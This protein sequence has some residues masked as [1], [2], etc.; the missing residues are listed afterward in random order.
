MSEKSGCTNIYGEFHP[1]L[2][3][4]KVEAVAVWTGAPDHAQHAIDAL[5]AGKR[6]ISAAPAAMTLEDC[7]RLVDTVKKTGLTYMLAETS[8]FHSATMYWPK[9]IVETRRAIA[10]QK[11]TGL[12]GCLKF[13]RRLNYRLPPIR[14]L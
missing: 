13:H 12:D 6:V 4:P 1:M 10:E 9:P 2:K 11:P 14:T 7:A 5:N 3:D 8:C